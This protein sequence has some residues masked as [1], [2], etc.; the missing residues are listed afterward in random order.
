MSFITK[1]TCMLVK[2]KKTQFILDKVK[3]FYLENFIFRHNV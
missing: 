1:Q 2:Q 3:N